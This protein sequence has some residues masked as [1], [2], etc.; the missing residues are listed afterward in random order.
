[1]PLYVGASSKVLLAF[2]EPAVQELLFASA[3][4][5]AGLSREALLQQVS[6]TRRQGFATSVEEREPGAA[7]LSAPILSHGGK[8]VAALAASGPANR[9]TLEKML[10]HAPLLQ[11]AARRMGTMLR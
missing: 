6:D 3:D 10:E 7:A 8:L 1:M 9:L 11:K 2:A 5:P 4:L